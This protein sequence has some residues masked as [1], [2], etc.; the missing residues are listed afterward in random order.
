MFGLSLTTPA[1]LGIDISSTSVKLIQLS[2]KRNRYKVEAYAV[3]PLPVYAVA[4]K[5]LQ[6]IDA[7]AEAVKKCVKKSGTSAKHVA[8]AVAGSM[9]ITKTIAMPKSIKERDLEDQVLLEADQQIPYPLEEVNLDFEVMGENAE[10]NAM[11]DIL[12]AAVRSE[13]VEDRSAVIQSAGLTPKVVDIEP[14]A[15]EHTFELLNLDEEANLH[16]KTIAIVD[17]GATMTSLHVLREGTL[18]YTR[19]QPFGGKQLTE[20]IMR[21]YGLSYQDAGRAKRTGGL[22]ET[23]EEEVLEP[24]KQDM[25]QQVNR[26]LQFFFSSDV[27]SDIDHVFLGGGCAA[28]E[29]IL[30]QISDYVGIPVSL[31]APFN[32]LEIASGI[33]QPRLLEDAPSLLIACGLALRGF[34]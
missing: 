14:Y 33:S 6:D 9:V 4:E 3:E 11:N 29:G 2:R 25:A 10:D 16:D 21:R 13:Q 24:F 8:V 34:D 32:G 7:V 26:H 27:S 30:Q 20:E 17:V 22:P 28:I 18:I 31:V 23:Y 1:V 19:E 15:V 12:V 5:A